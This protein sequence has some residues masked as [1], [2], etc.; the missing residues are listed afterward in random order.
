[1]KSQAQ[2]FG[3][4]M[5][6]PRRHLGRTVFILPS[7]FTV[8][9]IFCGYYAIISAMHEHYDFAAQAIGIAIILDMLDGRIARLTNSE[10]G[11][12]LQLDSLAD[13]I[14]F[15][16]APSVLAFCWGLTVLN[17]QLGWIA[18]FT[19]TICGAMRLARFNVQAGLFKHFV[20]LPIPAGGGAVA[21]VVHFWVEPVTSPL[22]SGLLV[23]GIFLLAFLM[24]STFRY[25]SLKNLTLGRKSHFT[26]LIIAL[27][28]A[29]IYNYSDWTLLII[30]LTYAASGPVAKFYSMA[31]HRR[32]S[33]EA[34][35]VQEAGK[36]N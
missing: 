33:P 3:S 19:F 29:L 27:L 21:A 8:S 16:I 26:I 22:A 23:A 31:R 5:T 10:T 18:A 36:G 13:V 6:H 4:M 12:G 32:R 11:F 34:L 24:I 20:G 1:M 14:S 2:L 35:R 9:N 15:G 28:V 25:S 7:L 30:A 17:Y